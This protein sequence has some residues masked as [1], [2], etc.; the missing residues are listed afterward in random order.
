[1]AEP[2]NLNTLTGLG[3]DKLYYLSETTGQVKEANWWMR[4]KCFLGI[5]SARQKISNLVTA[6]RASLLKLTGETNNATL[7]SDLDGINRNKL[8]KGEMITTIAKNFCVANGT[9]I[10]KRVAAVEAEKFSAKCAFDFYRYYNENPSKA[11]KTT[12]IDANCDTVFS[13]LFNHAFKPVI[14]GPLPMKEGYRLNM[15]EF[16]RLLNNKAVEVNNL[17][18]EILKKIDFKGG[19]EGKP[20]V[21]QIIISLFNDD[22]TRKTNIRVDDLEP[23]GKVTAAK[24]KE[25]EELEG[26]VEG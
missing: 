20:F 23:S 13:D 6:V 26:D 10:A 12:S 14:N 1:M 3:A 22:G 25:L 18:D 15:N 11:A 16:D 21:N 19:K 4:F 2:L 8:V 7:E 17:L 9:K 5:S 24:L